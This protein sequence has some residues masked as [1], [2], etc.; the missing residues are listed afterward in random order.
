MATANVNLGRIRIGK[1]RIRLYLAPVQAA[2]ERLKM[3]L[4]VRSNT[5]LEVPI[6][7]FIA[8]AMAAHAPSPAEE[9]ETLVTGTITKAWSRFM[10]GAGSRIMR[11]ATN[12][13]RSASPG[14]FGRVGTH[15]GERFL[16]KGTQLYLVEALRIQKMKVAR[17]K[18]GIGNPLVRV[19]GRFGSWKHM[20]KRTG[21]SYVT[22][23]RSGSHLVK[24]ETRKTLPFNMDW[25]R[26][27]N[28]GGTW[29]VRP[30]PKGGKR[31]GILHPEPGVYAREMLKTVKPYRYAQKGLRDTMKWLKGAIHP[32]VVIPSLRGAGFIMKTA[33]GK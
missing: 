27:A 31:F 16:K 4:A 33:G 10:P 7:A 20:A 6:K 18:I 1:S 24:G 12:A 29:L 32:M 3:Q 30:R 11:R 14:S 25:P 26:T 19:V 15:E 28:Y 21:F 17:T 13:A 23:K 5:A 9:R 2:L 8:D 22:H